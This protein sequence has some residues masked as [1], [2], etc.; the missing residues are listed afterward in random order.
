MSRPR[1]QS[2]IIIWDGLG[3]PVASLGTY[4]AGKSLVFREPFRPLPSINSNP[5]APGG[6]SRC[7]IAPIQAMCPIAS[8]LAVLCR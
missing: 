2:R 4:R 7:R 3:V 6:P 8:L 5:V 1:R